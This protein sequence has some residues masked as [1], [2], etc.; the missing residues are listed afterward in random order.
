MLGKIDIKQ[1][2]TISSI[3]T[4]TTLRSSGNEEESSKQTQKADRV[5]SS[6]FSVDEKF[7]PI[8]ITPESDRFPYQIN[9]SMFFLRTRSASLKIIDRKTH[10][11]LEKLGPVLYTS[12]Y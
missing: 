5:M 9:P 10:I 3:F 7:N 4:I 1:S 8:K 6:Y 12:A 2:Y 11:D